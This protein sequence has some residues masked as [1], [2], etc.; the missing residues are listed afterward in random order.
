VVAPFGRSRPGPAAAKQP[1]T[2]P[3]W[4]AE[5]V[6]DELNIEYPWMR[7]GLIATDRSADAPCIVGWYGA[8]NKI[9]DSGQISAVLRDWERR[10]ATRVVGADFGTLH[11]SVA[12]PPEDEREALSVAA[13]HFALCPDNV[14]QRLLPFG[15]AAEISGYADE[16]V[17]SPSRSFWWD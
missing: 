16:L 12:A 2:D 10:F 3:G 1:R 6:A 17:A 9:G 13:E 14:W 15:Q 4:Q 7:L 8:V 11:L 5:Q